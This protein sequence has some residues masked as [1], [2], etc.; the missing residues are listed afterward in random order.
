V[1]I[2]SALLYVCKVIWLVGF[3]IT[4]KRERYIEVRFWVKGICL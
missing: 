3:V 1:S 2:Y 4:I